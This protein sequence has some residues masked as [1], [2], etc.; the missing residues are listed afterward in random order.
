MGD[1]YDD[2]GIQ[3]WMERGDE[4]N[5]ISPPSHDE[6]C[7]ELLEIRRRVLLGPLRTSNKQF[8]NDYNDGNS[9]QKFSSFRYFAPFFLQIRKAFARY[10]HEGNIKIL[11]IL[12]GIVSDS[13]SFIQDRAIQLQPLIPD[14]IFN[15]MHEGLQRD[16]EELLIRLT[17]EEECVEMIQAE[18]EIA[19]LNSNN[20]SF[21]ETINSFSNRSPYGKKQ[22]TRK[23]SF[24]ENGDKSSQQMDGYPQGL[25]LGND[26]G[27]NFSSTIDKK[28]Y[29]DD[30]GLKSPRIMD[31]SFLPHSITE[32]WLLAKSI[33]ELTVVLD[34]IISLYDSLP[35]LAREKT[36]QDLPKLLRHISQNLTFEIYEVTMQCI[37]LLD[38][39]AQDNVDYF[40]PHLHTI[41]PQLLKGLDDTKEQL[42]TSCLKFICF[43]VANISFCLTTKWI[44]QAL[45]LKKKKGKCYPLDAMKVASMG[46]LKCTQESGS[47]LVGSDRISLLRISTAAAAHL[48]DQ[49]NEDSSSGSDSESND[50]A[51]DIIASSMSLLF[52]SNSATQETVFLKF[53]DMIVPEAS[54]QKLDYDIQSLIL[55]R[56]TSGD[57]S[58]AFS[59][60]RKD[61]NIADILKAVSNSKDYSS[62]SS[63][64]FSSKLP[65][66]ED[67]A[68]SEAASFTLLSP[69]EEED[70]VFDP[71]EYKATT[72][73]T[74]T[75]HTSTDGGVTTLPLNHTTMKKEAAVVPLISEKREGL[76]RSV[77]GN[78]KKK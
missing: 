75:P 15:L 48:V 63:S 46:I 19:I 68:V 39:I 43:L 23:Q 58:L 10:R 60:L 37:K 31:I 70:F 4:N 40:G 24:N 62:S 13:I 21:I 34:D 73:T 28:V 27:L 71:T 7:D 32:Q 52:P 11:Q 69:F 67:L 14:L 50:L 9:P 33:N 65:T 6:L 5:R 36:K 2:Y 30:A 49:L 8:T 35:S 25:G 22:R 77:N 16:T 44:L 76:H 78:V 17:D 18:M 41:L 3:K 29:Y 74:T 56:A 1:L 66:Y 26:F 53:L 45:D 12:T 57:K 59:S 20:K 38:M 47:V 72:T 61:K 54:G 64:S 42:R 55:G 51:L